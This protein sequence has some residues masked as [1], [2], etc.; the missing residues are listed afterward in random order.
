MSLPT[1]RLACR[2]MVLL[3]FA[4]AAA[5]ALPLPLRAQAPPAERGAELSVALVTMGPG[6]LVWERFGHNAIL[7]RD[8]VRGTERSF[9]Y[10]IFDFAQENFILRFVQGRM[11]YYMV[12]N[13]ARRELAAYVRGNRSVW[14]QELDLTPAQRADLRDFLEWNELPENRDYRYDYY[15]D[16]CSTRVRDAI[17]RVIGGE[18]ATQTAGAPAGTTYRFHTRRLVAS[19]P[20]TYTGLELGL[21]SPVD[22]PITRWEEMFLPLAFREQVRTI[23]VA[24]PDGARRPLVKSEATLYTSTTPEARNIPPTWWPYYLM[25]G[26]L[27]GATLLMLGERLGESRGARLAFGIVGGAWELLAGLAGVLLAGLLFT[28]HAAAHANE[29]LFQA[30]PLSVA[31]AV[32]VPLMAIRRGRL[33]RLTMVLALAVG[34]IGVAGVVFKLVPGVRQ[35]NGEIIALAL[36]IHL[37]VAVTAWRLSRHATAQA[38]AHA[39]AHATARGS[40]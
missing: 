18:I 3:T 9:N 15:R 6:K 10:G 21:G 33:S 22:R 20:L 19:D 36:P 14:V 39:T 4:A 13:D 29:N 5:A 38:T 2:S 31:L 37:A 28:D 8:S 32:L 27:I 34:L 16:N 24:G 40:A 7:I 25:A 17:D 12:G 1:R 35:V 11:L 23:T 30:N 26:I